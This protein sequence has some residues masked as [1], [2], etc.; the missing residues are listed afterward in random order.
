MSADGQTTKEVDQL[1]EA[2]VNKLRVNR[3]VLE[4]SIHHGRVSWRYSKK[5]GEF[6]V[7]LEPKL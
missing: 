4:R 5:N 6:E 1:I 7:N 2:I 3:A